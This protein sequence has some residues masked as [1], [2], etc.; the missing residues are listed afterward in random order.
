MTSPFIMIIS[1]FSSTAS[2]LIQR[3]HLLMSL[4]SLEAMMLSMACFIMFSIGSTIQWNPFLFIVVLT[5]GACEAS[6]GLSLLVIITRTSGSD[7]MKTLSS[8]KC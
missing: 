4:L 6:L 2:L 3:K 8:S 7:M 1:F 5:F